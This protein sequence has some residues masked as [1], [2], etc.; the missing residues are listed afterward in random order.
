MAIEL[1]KAAEDTE[2]IKASKAF[3]KSKTSKA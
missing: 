3:I 1:L 2:A